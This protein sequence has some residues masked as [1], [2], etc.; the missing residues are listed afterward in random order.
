MIEIS[1]KTKELKDLKRVAGISDERY[2]QHSIFV[3]LIGDKNPFST[4]QKYIENWTT[5]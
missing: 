4:W 1:M 3:I 2:L 5:C